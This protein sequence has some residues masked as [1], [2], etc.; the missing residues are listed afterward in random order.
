MM[1]PRFILT[2]LISLPSLTVLQACSSG[3]EKA[4]NTSG[5]VSSSGMPAS[6]NAAQPAAPASSTALAAG[7]V[8]MRPVTGTTGK[9]Q[10][11]GDAKGYREDP[12]NITVK[13][14][15]AVQWTNVSG[16]PHNILVL[17]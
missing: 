15:D 3:G 4:A 12:Y 13:A 11:L 14:G 16:G 10:M 17:A 1:A 7:A 2:A 6:G 9:V 8:A 5:N